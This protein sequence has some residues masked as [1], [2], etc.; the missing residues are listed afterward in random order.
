MKAFFKSYLSF[1]TASTMSAV[2]I[3][4]QFTIYVKLGTIVG[5]SIETIETSLGDSYQ[6]TKIISKVIGNG[7]L[8]D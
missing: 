7:S 6:C 2:I 5:I 3:N 8:F 1:N 4:N